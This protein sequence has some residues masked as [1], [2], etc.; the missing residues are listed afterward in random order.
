MSNQIDHINYALAK[1]IPNMERGFSIGT[2]YGH[3][4]VDEEEAASFIKLAQKMMEKRLKRAEK[5]Q[6][7]SA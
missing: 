1:Q 7:I 2:N 4:F 5:A 6:G 3:I